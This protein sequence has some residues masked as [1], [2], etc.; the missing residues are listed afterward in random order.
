VIFSL[1]KARVPALSGAKVSG[2]S[3]PDKGKS[4]PREPTV[5]DRASLS[6]YQATAHS[7]KGIPQKKDNKGFAL[8]Y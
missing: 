2:S 5:I 7:E 1:T 8:L 4:T 3:T 6:T